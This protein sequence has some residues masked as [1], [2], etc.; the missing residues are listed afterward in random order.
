MDD[1]CTHD[2]GPLAEGAL[3]GDVIECPRHGARFDIRTG[4]ALTLPAIEP[5]PTYAVRVVG[6]E[7]QVACESCE[8]KR[9]AQ[10]GGGHGARAEAG[11]RVRAGAG[12]GRRSAG[13]APARRRQQELAV[14]AALE[15]VMD[16]EI[17]LS[18]HRPRADPRD[19]H[20]A[21]DAR[22]SA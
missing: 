17:Q 21:R 4:A 14:R 15:T 18:V 13:A 3:E 10:A 8:E 6:D 7:I 5:V 20:R 16:P 9:A 19:P 1:V 11:G 22:S 2:G 12:A